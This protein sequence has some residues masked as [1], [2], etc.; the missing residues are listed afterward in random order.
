MEYLK[1]LA[2]DNIEEAT[3]CGPK[4]ETGDDEAPIEFIVTHNKTNYTVSMPLSSTIKELKDKMFDII[5]VSSQVQKVMVK[6]LARDDQTLESLNIN[7]SSK[8][9]V[10]GNRLIDIIAAARVNE[11]PSTT[12]PS[13][14]AKEP[15]CKS[16]LHLKM[17]EKGIPDNAMIGILNI[18][19]SLPI[20]PLSGMLDKYGAKVRLTFK[21]ELDELWISTKERTQKL[22]MASIKNIVSEPIEGYEQYYIM[23]FQLDKTEASNYWLYWVPAQY[24]DSIKRAVFGG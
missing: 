19:E 22:P 16:K 2:D 21:L 4:K 20:R 6:G 24:V 5:G 13:T 8:I 10:V 17:V 3:A 9:M 15:L 14:S 7:S 12:K 1:E 11:D 18:K 23:G